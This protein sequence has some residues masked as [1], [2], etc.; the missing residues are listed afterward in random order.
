MYLTPLAATHLTSAVMALVLGL[1][2]F[3]ATKGTS[4]HRMMGAGYVVAMLAVNVTALG[5]YRLTGSFNMFHFFALV[6]LVAIAA[7]LW[8]LVQRKEGWLRAHYRPMVG[9]Y[10]GLWA[11]AVAEATTRLPIMRGVLTTPTSIITFGVS[12]AVV[13]VVPAY[14]VN[15]RFA[16]LSTAQNSQPDPRRTAA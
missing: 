8:P 16:T 1:S 15:R 7:G 6:S 5:M 3:P 12:I 13:F 9:S 4:F 10:F 14:I 2:V 11:A